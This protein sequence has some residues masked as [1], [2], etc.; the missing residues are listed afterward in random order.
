MQAIGR[1]WADDGLTRA[2][3]RL[4]LPCLGGRNALQIPARGKA[5]ECCDG[6][7]RGVS[8][9]S[10]CRVGG[11]DGQVDREGYHQECIPVQELPVLGM[12]DLI[13][14]GNEDSDKVGRNT[15]LV[16]QHFDDCCWQEGINFLKRS[17]ASAV[18]CFLDAYAENQIWQKLRLMTVMTSPT[19]GPPDRL[20]QMGLY[21]VGRH[22]HAIQDFYSHSNWTSLTGPTTVPEY[23]REESIDPGA[24]RV[25][26]DLSRPSFFSL[27]R[28]WAGSTGG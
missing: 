3:G 14:E 4:S 13:C 25:R 7:V 24:L 20:I 18:Q 15:I 27:G 1:R 21:A 8:L 5:P 22:F 28:S 10:S 23:W 9:T 11:N 26:R 12:P 2:I 17:R 16:S 19:I 6:A